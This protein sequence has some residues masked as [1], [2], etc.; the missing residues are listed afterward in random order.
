MFRSYFSII[1]LT[2]LVTSLTGCATVPLPGKGFTTPQSVRPVKPLM[3][4]REGTVS[5]KPSSN[6]SAK[7][8]TQSGTKLGVKSNPSAQSG[9][10][11]P[12]S[13]V[14]PKLQEAEDK[15]ASARSLSQSAQTEDD[16]TLV[17]QQWKRALAL[18]P[19][20]SAT[21]PLLGKVQQARSTYT[22]SL[23]SAQAQAQGFGKPTTTAPLEVDRNKSGRRGM[24]LG[25]DPSP[26]PSATP[27]DQPGKPAG[28]PTDKP[29]DK[30]GDKP[31]EPPKNTST[32]TPPVKN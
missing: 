6:P 14:A 27:T 15:A 16:W 2:L 19:N 8:G 29:T 32:P 26:S 30:P 12:D 5:Q 25:P 20:P 10:T 22:N 24:I 13:R 28:K 21:S 31:A 4:G 18:L 23:Q 11:V 1:A 17:A 3:E 9:Q 7:P